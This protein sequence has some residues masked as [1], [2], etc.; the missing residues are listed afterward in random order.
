MA[1]VSTK[2][3][4]KLPTRFAILRLPLPALEFRNH[5]WDTTSVV[6]ALDERVLLPGIRTGG[7]D[8]RSY[9]DLPRQTGRI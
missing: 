9:E 7:G 8:A 5:T 2:K 6:R 1:G 3:P 4:H